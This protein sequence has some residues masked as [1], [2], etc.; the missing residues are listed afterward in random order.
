MKG[1]LLKYKWSL[2]FLIFIL[3]IYGFRF[4]LLSSIGNFLISEDEPQKA[5]V[6][7]VLG[8]NSK[9]RGVKAAELFI[10]DYSSQIVCL[11]GNNH[12]AL[13]DFGIDAKESEVTKKVIVNQGV[14]KDSI[15]VLAEGT[16][17]YEEKLSVLKDIK[18][19]NYQLNE[20]HQ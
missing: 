16:S 1:K 7:Y 5:D 3:S 19:H 12:D 2:I 10:N 14:P 13:V 9:D 15:R 18:K 6:I 11:G 8:G 20:P 17:T 4:Q